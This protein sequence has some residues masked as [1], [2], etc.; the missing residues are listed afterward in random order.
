MGLTA[1]QIAVHVAHW[2][3]ALGKTFRSYRDKWPSRLGEGDGV[4][5]LGF[6]MGMSGLLRN[7][8]I[9]RQ[10]SVARIAE[11]MDG[12]AD[13][14][15]IDSLIYP[16]NSGGPVMLRPEG[17]FSSIEGANTNNNAYLIG[18]VIEYIPY[19]DE[20][21]SMQTG[22]PR[23]TFEE[24]SGLGKILPVDYIHDAVLAAQ[25][26]SPPQTAPAKKEIVGSR[27]G[28]EPQPGSRCSHVDH[29][30]RSRRL[31]AFGAG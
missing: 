6:P 25:V 31:G 14:F 22:R 10:G 30:C 20:A 26:V 4:F 11:L 3:D 8:V 28:D 29:G 27:R 13:Y 21:V 17:I 2:E 5:V 1:A 24:H 23:I 18:I 12:A 16:G 7:Y 19:I 9:V 15:L